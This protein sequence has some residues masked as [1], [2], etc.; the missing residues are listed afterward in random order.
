MVYSL[1]RQ[2]HG[3]GPGF[4]TA[5]MG[6]RRGESIKT[7]GSGVPQANMLVLHSFGIIR[8]D[9]LN[10]EKSENGESRARERDLYSTF[11][12]HSTIP[13][14]PEEGKREEEL[15]INMLQYCFSGRGV[16]K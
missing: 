4:S 8:I 12:E 3:G 9:T 1:W 7:L 5:S 10:I 14:L 13:L 16:F 15:R 6:S 2:G 11:A